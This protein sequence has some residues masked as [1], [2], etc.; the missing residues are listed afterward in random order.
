MVPYFPSQAL[1]IVEDG[2]ERLEK[3]SKAFI[4][5][6][7]RGKKKREKNKSVGVKFRA[8]KGTISGKYPKISLGLSM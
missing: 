6:V 3:L 5:F 4:G 7:G 8:P 2:A 1:L